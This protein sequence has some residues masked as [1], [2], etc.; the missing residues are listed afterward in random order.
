[1]LFN[2][3]CVRI[4]DNGYWA[5]TV[6]QA[7][8]WDGTKYMLNTFDFLPPFAYWMVTTAVELG[9]RERGVGLGDDIPL[10]NQQCKRQWTTSSG[11]SSWNLSWRS[12]FWLRWAA[13]EVFG[14]SE[15]LLCLKGNT[16]MYLYFLSYLNSK[17]QKLIVFPFKH[18]LLLAGLFRFF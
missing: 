1:M 7:L 13:S 16:V 14:S 11:A 8:R 12:D 10:L 17:L 4:T 18:Y 3:V 15:R 9:R 2:T 6:S 5:C